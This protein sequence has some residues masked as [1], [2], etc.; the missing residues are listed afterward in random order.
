[1]LVS[2]II[3]AY[4]VEKYISKTL[5]SLLNQTNK[6]F[7]IIVVNDGSTDKTLEVANNILQRSKFKNFKI[8]NK[9]NGGVS[10]ARNAGLKEAK[11]D[12]VIF[13]DGDDYVN[14]RLVE[15]IEKFSK[16]SEPEIITWKYSH[17]YLCKNNIK[18]KNVHEFNGL[19]ENIIY[20]GKDV[21]TKILVERNFWIAINNGAYNR[22]FIKQYNLYFIEDCI[23]NEDLEFTFKSL[24]VANKILF[25]DEILS[26]YLQRK[27][28]I[29][30]SLNLKRFGGFF[31][32]ER[33]LDFFIQH[34]I[35]EDN[36]INSLRILRFKF[37][38]DNLSLFS[39][40][41]NYHEF[42]IKIEKY[43]PELIEL[44][45]KETKRLN[46]PYKNLK[47]RLKRDLYTLSPFCYFY[48]IKFINIVKK[49]II[50]IKL[51]SR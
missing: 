7:E 9:E 14:E 29:T 12:Y 46:I 44:V 27:N 34:N 18:F 16:N 42:K 1:M 51:K 43:F 22:K 20:N 39:K 32:F 13:L 15:K 49:I 47:L 30:K 45:R 35:S 28:S 5:E 36:L 23:Y 2:F 24:A 21:L 33:V 10:S 25:I 19:E 38:I 8:I 4:N 17:V 37:F 3:P 11:G 6:N 48:V 31:A 26:Y 41:H 50:G 40:F